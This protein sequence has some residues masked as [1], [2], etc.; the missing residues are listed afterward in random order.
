MLNL[1]LYAY[2]AN[3]PLRYSDPTGH[4]VGDVHLTNGTVVQAS[5]VNGHTVMPGGGAMPVGAIVETAGGLYQMTSS[6]G[7]KVDAIVTTPSG[8]VAGQL[9]DNKTYVN[10]N[11]V[12]NGSVVTIGD[13]TNYMMIN[14]AGKVVAP[15]TV[16]LPNNGGSTTG[17]NANGT[18]YMIGGSRPSNGSI[19]QTNGGDYLMTNNGGVLV[20]MTDILEMVILGLSCHRNTKPF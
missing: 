3:N 7:V 11:R 13:G 18:T 20:C 17:Y 9:V 5:I 6:G 12:T 2:C 4:K 16:L 15:T 1:N 8:A 19:V 14:G 10:G